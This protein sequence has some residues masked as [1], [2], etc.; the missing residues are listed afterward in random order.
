M[1]IGR[2]PVVLA[3]RLLELSRADLIFGLGLGTGLVVVLGS[4]GL[5]YRWGL[6]TLFDGQVFSLV[7]IPGVD[8]PLF[9]QWLGI[10]VPV[11]TTLALVAFAVLVSLPAVSRPRLVTA[12]A[13]GFA[14]GAA[15]IGLVKGMRYHH[16]LLLSLDVPPLGVVRWPV[17]LVPSAL[18]LLLLVVI[19]ARWLWRFRQHN[20][21]LPVA[22]EAAVLIWLGNRQERKE[23]IDQAEK[24]FRR[25]YERTRARL[26]EDDPRALGPLVKL[27]WF[28]YDHP[29][30]DESEAGRLFRKGMAIA[31]KGQ[32]VERA[33][34]AH[35]LDGLGSTAFREGDSHEALRLYAQ[36][37]RVAEEA[38]GAL[39]WRVALPLRHLAYATMVDSK[40]EEAERLSERSLAIARRNY[41]RR[42]QQLVSFIATLALIREEQGRFEDAVRLREE[43]LQLVGD[44]REPNTV[45]ARALFEL[46]RTLGRQGKSHEAETRYEQAL[47]MASDGRADRRQ[48]VPDALLGLASL[49]R[50]EGR[51]SEAELFARQALAEGEALWGGDSLRVVVPLVRLGDLYTKQDKPEEARSSLNRAMAIIESRSGPADATLA[52]PLELFGLLERDQGNYELAE[53]MT[54]RAIAVTEAH[55]GP[56]DRHLVPLLALLG[57]IASERENHIDAIQIFERGLTV[58]EKAYGRNRPQTT[59]F[60]ANLAHEREVIDDSAGAERLHREEINALQGWPEAH[61]SELADAFERL[62]DF[63]ERHDRSDEAVEA[64]RQSIEV[65]VKH[66]WENPADSI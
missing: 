64:K 3:S 14:T 37:V 57:S 8:H 23:R 2:L 25:A 22:I 62:A 32:H 65:M 17:V 12:I 60:L 18:A 63:L 35:L 50:A 34:L 59:Q 55:Q 44:R 56:D 41:G 40:L 20:G 45:R 10:K 1:P 13:V 33:L 51:F 19:D 11:I 52:I 49:R 46:A 6:H 47:A 4:D 31:E 38:G 27:A 54:R 66:A 7:Q 28:T 29:T 61:D 21:P 16:D 43:G 58:S 5:L 15:I 30:D 26:G 36:A 53:T 48:V 39:S 24:T 9:L 42:S